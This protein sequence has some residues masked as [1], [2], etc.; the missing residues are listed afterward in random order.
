M[1]TQ[2]APDNQQK[3]VEDAKDK[4]R[5]CVER[6]EAIVML[7]ANHRVDQQRLP[8]LAGLTETMIS[9]LKVCYENLSPDARRLCKTVKIQTQ[10]CHRLGREVARADQVRLIRLAQEFT[11]ERESKRPLQKMGSPGRQSPRGLI[12]EDDMQKAIC[13]EKYKS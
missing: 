2:Q 5:G 8:T 10:A 1:T 9:R 13:A 3:L 4:K 7:L 12:T 6:G 11:R